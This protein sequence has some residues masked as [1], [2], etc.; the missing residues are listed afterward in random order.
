MK[1]V[2]EKLATWHRLYQ[3]LRTA[4]SRLKLAHGPCA[5]ELQNEVKRLAGESDRAMDAVHAALA[6]RELSSRA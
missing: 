6:T 5:A 3:D 1:R 2:E 4:E